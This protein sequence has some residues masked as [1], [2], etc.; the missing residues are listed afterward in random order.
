MGLGERE[1]TSKPTYWLTAYPN[2][3]SWD[4]SF[5]CRELKGRVHMAWGAGRG[6][7]ALSH[8]LCS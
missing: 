7:V 2:E 4:R 5:A 3:I 1:A 6:G 8:Q